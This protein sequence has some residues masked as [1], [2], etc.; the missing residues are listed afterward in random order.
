MVLRQSRNLS[1]R[2]HEEKN[3]LQYCFL[4]AALIILLF[5]LGHFIFGE[6]NKNESINR[7]FMYFITLGILDVFLEIWTSL[8]QNKAD[9][10]QAG[11][12]FLL[13][14]LFYV[15]QILF[16]FSLYLYAI[17]LRSG[18]SLRAMLRA[19][20][21]VLIGPVLMFGFLFSTHWTHFL[22]YN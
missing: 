10:G 12:L 8:I 7:I 17:Y 2:N 19:R 15:M 22:F 13:T 9:S 20:W 4:F 1:L 6:W 5:I 11:L 16:P 21:Q 3:D 18:D 14:T